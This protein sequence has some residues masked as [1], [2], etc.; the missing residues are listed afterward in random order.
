MQRLLEILQNLAM[1]FQHD[2]DIQLAL[3][4]GARIAVGYYAKS[5]QWDDMHTAFRILMETADRSPDTLEFQKDLAGGTVEV[6]FP[7]KQANAGVS[8][9][10]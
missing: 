3:T 5:R 2:R 7:M 1:L 9:K 6:I 8:C 10:R 4:K